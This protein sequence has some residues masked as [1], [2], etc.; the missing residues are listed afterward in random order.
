VPAQKETEA[1]LHNTLRLQRIPVIH[2]FLLR[3]I[4]IVARRH[5]D[6]KKNGRKKKNFQ[7]DRKI[8]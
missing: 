4:V 5:C 7:R 1:L 3:F 6:H 8:P 2:G